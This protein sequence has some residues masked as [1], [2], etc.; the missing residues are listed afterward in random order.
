MGQ[1]GVTAAQGLR[2]GRVQGAEALDVHFIDHPL[3]RVDLRSG[4]GQRRQ[5]GHHPGFERACCVVT[6]IAQF[7][8][9]GQMTAMQI[10]AVVAS[11]DFAGVGVE[12]ELGGI[13]ALTGRGLPG[14][15]HTPTVYQAFALPRW[16][17]QAAMPQALVCSAQ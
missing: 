1:A 17:G 15:M 8:L 10:T 5:V 3:R 2:Y 6:Q 16:Q 7:R 13:E 11:D 9:T 4:L 14:A 12:Q